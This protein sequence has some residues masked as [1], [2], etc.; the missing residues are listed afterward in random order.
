MEETI[1]IQEEK[2]FRPR[3]RREERGGERFQGILKKAIRVA[4]QLLLLSL[5]FFIGHRVYVHLLEDP[6]FGVKEVEVEGNRKIPRETVLSLTE[7]EGMP[8]LFTLKLKEVAKRLVLHPWIEQVK[9]SK[10][11]PNKIYIQIEERKPIAIL[12]LEELYYIDT[13]GVIFSPV[14]DRDPYNYPFLTGLTRQA[15]EKDPVET[16]RLIMKALEFL[17]IVYKERV[18][19]PEEISEIHMEKTFG[20]QYF[21]K[22][23]GVEVRM[24]WEQFGEKLRRL[25]IIWS[26]LRKRGLSAVSID[27]SDLKRMVVKK[28]SS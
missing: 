11:F 26:D 13:K 14:G 23:E 2:F 28:P 16:K 20:I 4:F 9:V 6:F 22:A 15:L 12:Q 25:S 5:F 21:T 17:R 27:C 7:M 24:G 3:K 19:P 10:V 8:N 1:T 18:F